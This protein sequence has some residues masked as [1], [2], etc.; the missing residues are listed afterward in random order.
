MLRVKSAFASDGPRQR[1]RRE[2]AT[3][4]ART[5]RGTRFEVI[6]ALHRRILRCVG[7]TRSQL[8]LAA[9]SLFSLGCDTVL[10]ADFDDDRELPPDCVPGEP[11]GADDLGRCTAE[12][13]CKGR[14]TKL[15]AMFR[16]TCAILHDGSVWCWGE[17]KFGEVGDGTQE[18]HA[19]AWRVLNLPRAREIAAG[20]GHTCIISVKDEVWCWGD[21]HAGQCGGTPTPGL[22]PEP[23][24]PQKV[25]GLDG[26]RLDQLTA[27][28]GHTCG[29]SHAEGAA[30][31][32][33]LNNEKQIGNHSASILPVTKLDLDH[34][35]SIHAMKATT[36]V[37][38]NADPRLVCWGR[39]ALGQLGPAAQG[40]LSTG[41]PIPI[42]LP[43]GVGVAGVGMAHE[44]TFAVGDDGRAYAWGSN[45]R[46]QCGG[47]DEATGE[48]PPLVTEPTAVQ[49]DHPEVGLL[50]LEDV[51]QIHFADSSNQCVMVNN[52]GLYGASIVCWGG[53]DG[54]F[55]RGVLENPPGQIFPRAQPALALPAGLRG[56]AYG[57]DHGCGL[58]PVNENEDDIVCWG[59]GGYVASGQVTPLP[60]QLEPL[61]I[62]WAPAE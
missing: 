25:P 56:L 31:C 11:C 57:E 33:G 54:E 22:A 62:K 26:I 38:R 53:D 24:F 43:A 49:F 3:R 37:T 20:E 15:A 55:G 27:G 28:R 21:N 6:S 12:R 46:G 35:A 61:P 2:H 34:V 58:L 17:N 47:Y 14:D 45:K 60:V 8:A 29:V 42:E 32:W 30:Y 23:V 18:F 4:V 7:L 36:C 5:R 40:V 51:I 10:G 48:I 16:H 1:Q 59:Y 13:A 52:P 19:K 41:D 44:S 39:N 9:L 50:P